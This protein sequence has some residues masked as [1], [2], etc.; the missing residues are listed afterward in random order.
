MAAAMDSCCMRQISRSSATANSGSMPAKT[1]FSLSRRA[2]KPCTVETQARSSWRALSRV[3]VE[4]LG[5]LLAHVAGGLLGE[6]DGQNAQRVHAALPPGAGNIPPAR[7]SCPSPGPA[8]TQA[9]RWRAAISTAAQLRGGEIDFASCALRQ[10]G[11]RCLPG[12]D[13]AHV[14]RNRRSGTCRGRRRDFHAPA[15]DLCHRPRASARRLRSSQSSGIGSL[16]TGRH[17]SSRRIR[18]RPSARRRTCRR[19]SDRKCLSAAIR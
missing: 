9:S 6:G 12:L 5:Q 8:T 4:R 3:V 17:R 1:A 18:R 13:A 10:R 16:S 15:A 19:P 14:A 11:R 7:W 2:Q